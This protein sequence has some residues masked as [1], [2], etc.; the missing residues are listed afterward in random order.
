MVS[1][2]FNARVIITVQDLVD[3]TFST[4]C[5]ILLNDTL[6]FLKATKLLRITEIAKLKSTML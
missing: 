4:K 1:S 6:K 2:V 3:T 5:E